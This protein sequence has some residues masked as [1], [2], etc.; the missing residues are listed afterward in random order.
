MY[1]AVNKDGILFL[2][3]EEQEI[4]KISP[5]ATWVK[6]GDQFTENEIEISEIYCYCGHTDK[7]SC[8]PNEGNTYKP[9]II[10]ILGPCKHFH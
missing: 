4:E 8:G 6:E 1:K 2:Y 7:C 9:S 10:K 5:E 3:K